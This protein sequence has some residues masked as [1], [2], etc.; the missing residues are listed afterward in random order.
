MT[1][2]RKWGL[3]GAGLALLILAAPIIVA[4]VV[5]RTLIARS[6]D[7]GITLTIESAA[8]SFR[9]VVLRGLS[10]RLQDIPEASASIAEVEVVLLG[11]QKARASGV[12]VEVHGSAEWLRARYAA[13][14]SKTVAS[15]RPALPE[16]EVSGIHAS[17]SSALGPESL[18]EIFESSAAISADS[19][20]ASFSSLVQISFGPTTLQTLSVRYDENARRATF[21]AT[22]LAQALAGALV[23]AEIDHERIVTSTITI[24]RVPLSAWVTDKRALG[25]NPGLE[26]E[27]HVVLT[28]A[29]PPQTGDGR[30]RVD[31]KLFG[32]KF[33]SGSLPLD[34]SLLIDARRA[35]DDTLALDRG[36][37]HFGPLRGDLQGKLSIGAHIW[38]KLTFNAIP[39]PCSRFVT[40]RRNAKAGSV[41]ELAGNVTSLLEATGIARIEGSVGLKAQLDLDLDRKERARFAWKMLGGCSIALF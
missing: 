24:P 2:R 32:A 23:R 28:H 21:L 20:R 41:E 13:W 30:A 25:Y 40:E 39:I 7:H 1:R 12:R 15:T 37:A 29:A 16:L 27:A 8:P 22:P 10:A 35:S 34:A 3:A 33:Q 18:I 9:G 11:T 17:W 26:V 4:R 5:A 36:E 38:S 6:R 31:L 14:R 19:N